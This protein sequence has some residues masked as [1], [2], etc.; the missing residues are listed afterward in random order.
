MALDCISLSVGFLSPEITAGFMQPDLN[1]SAWRLYVTKITHTNQNPLALP[2]QSTR[3]QDRSQDLWTLIRLFPDSQ[4]AIPIWKIG[5]AR[6]E[7]DNRTSILVEQSSIVGFPKNHNMYCHFCTLS[8]AFIKGDWLTS[9]RCDFHKELDI[10]G[11]A[12]TIHIA[13]HDLWRVNRLLFLN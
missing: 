6:N 11:Y 13:M 1:R 10:N 12:I 4:Q 5:N 3:S 7:I 8:S 9:G 2:H